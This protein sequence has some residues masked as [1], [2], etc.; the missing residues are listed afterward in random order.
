M[1]R[2]CHKPSCDA[3]RQAGCAAVRLVALCC[4][5]LTLAGH[6]GAAVRNTLQ[7]PQKC[8]VSQQRR[9]DYFFYE[10]LKLKNAGKYDA[11]YE[12][13]NHC[14]AIDSTSSVVLFELSSLYM[15][16][17][18]SEKAMT[19]LKKAVTYNP[20]NFSYKLALA[21]ILFDLGM[22][23]EAAE[24]YEELVTAHPDQ[25]ELNY[26]LAEALTQQGETGR[27]IEM[28]DRLE[29]LIGMNE[30]LS[31]KKYQL[32]MTLEQPDEAFRELEKLSAKYPY[33]ARYPI[34]TGDL[35]LERNDTRRA[36][37]Y[38]RK[39]CD[40]DPENPYYTVSMANYYEM[41]GN[42]EAAEQQVRLALVNEKLDVEIKV[43]ILSRY[44]QRL[45]QLR[46]DIQ[47]ADSLFK[48]LLE[49]H[50]EEIEIKL[51]YG[52]LLSSQKKFGEAR[53]QFQLATEMDPTLEPA[54]QQL[55]SL[56]MQIEDYESVI[57]ICT[58]CRELFPD[59]PAYCL[60]M[61]IAYQQQQ[62]YQEALD[63]YMACIRIIPETN[64]QMLSDYYGQVGDV[65]FQMKKRDEAFESYEKALGYNEQNVVVLNNYSYYLSLSR[66]SLDKAERM[67]AKCIK[68]EPDNS[69]YLDTYAWVFFVK[70]NYTLAKIYIEKAVA[71]DGEK[72]AELLDHYGDILYMSGEKDKAHE[73]WLKAKQAGK[74][75]KTLERKIAENRYIETPED[76]E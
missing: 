71:K 4:L 75:G 65:Y 3:S 36:L 73:Q 70:G 62:K 63:T 31:L 12:L 54:W 11:M 74:K 16:M 49:Q 34:L 67:S 20:G 42:T 53:F 60:F 56:V 14:L 46:K 8:D 21:S 5:L 19:L 9:L 23:G 13:L 7:Q 18:R 72:N 17:N 69:T 61:G 47:A 28:F 76:E 45:Q 43:G 26:Y 33:E 57:A 52:A 44:I 27:A 40:I 66:Q 24:T 25:V 59:E 2:I 30:P 32:Y 15:Q 6:A 35:Y 58:K 55:L 10:A 41:T 37:E 48:T 50:P 68:A 22:Y 64:R 29:N 1:Y 38:Y 39:A 51:M